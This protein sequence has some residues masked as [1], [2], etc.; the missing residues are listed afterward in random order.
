MN[1]DRA[2]YTEYRQPKQV[3][4]HLRVRSIRLHGLE[5]CF[6]GREQR[7]SKSPLFTGRSLVVGVFMIYVRRLPA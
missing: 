4:W 1:C 5:K 6:R 3:I 7:I 2:R